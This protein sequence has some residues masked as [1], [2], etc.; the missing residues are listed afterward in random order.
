MSHRALKRLAVILGILCVLMVVHSGFLLWDM[1]F[2]GLR[3]A[4]ADEQTQ[5]FD[6][7]RA[8]ALASTSPRVIADSLQGATDYYRSGTRQQAG[9]PLDRIVERHRTA[10]VR[11]IITHFRR[12]TGEELGES[13]DPW[14]EKYGREPTGRKA[15]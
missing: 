1:A 14:I 3:V 9:S 2:L 6:D 13:S 10:V 4:F 12:T 7:M 8:Q 15:P 5:I 11:D